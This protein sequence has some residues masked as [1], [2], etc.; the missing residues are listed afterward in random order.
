M[1]SKEHIVATAIDLLRQNPHGLRYSA[2]RR[3]IQEALPDANPN[4]IGGT[5]WNLEA[6]MPKEVT[7]PARGLSQ[8]SGRGRFDSI[9]FTRYGGLANPLSSTK[10]DREATQAGR[11]C[12]V[13][14]L[15]NKSRQLVTGLACAWRARAPRDG[16]ACRS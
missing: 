6:Q 5:I 4:T 2:L 11:Q 1:T 7:K 10:S 13:P 9:R 16:A 15:K 8:T 12:L 14:V 3:H